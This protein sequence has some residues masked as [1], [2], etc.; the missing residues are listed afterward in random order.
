M[1]SAL[2]FNVSI[3][4][5]DFFSKEHL[6]ANTFHWG[7]RTWPPILLLMLV[8]SFQG[9]FDRFW[10]TRVL[11]HFDEVPENYSSTKYSLTSYLCGPWKLQSI[12]SYRSILS[13]T[14]F[15]VWNPWMEILLLLLLCLPMKAPTASFISLRFVIPNSYFITHYSPSWFF[16]KWINLF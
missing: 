13:D 3:S 9:V 7:L 14:I 15:F 10:L 12:S 11:F 2:C 5:K 1:S 4:A 8:L 6:C 16:F